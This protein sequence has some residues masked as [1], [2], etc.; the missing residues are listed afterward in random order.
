MM[1][2]NGRGSTDDDDAD[3]AYYYYYW[4]HDDDDA[5]TDDDD[6]DD[7]TLMVRTIIK[8]LYAMRIEMV[9]TLCNLQL[10][11][12]YC[13][14]SCVIDHDNNAQDFPGVDDDEE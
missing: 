1:L 8:F 3:D 11:C 2:L 12:C 10:A 9:K 7:D 6:E 4:H 14:L 13:C 5:D